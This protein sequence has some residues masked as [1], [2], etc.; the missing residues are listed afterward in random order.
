MVKN[1]LVFLMPFINTQRLMQRDK[2]KK[3]YKCL[4]EEVAKVDLRD[5]ETSSEVVIQVRLMN[6]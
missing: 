2:Y 1:L 6:I 4:D 5:D 3:L